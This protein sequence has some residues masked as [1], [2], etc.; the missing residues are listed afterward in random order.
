[1]NLTDKNNMICKNCKYFSCNISKNSKIDDP[2]GYCLKHD[3]QPHCN[4]KHKCFVY[5]DHLICTKAT[6]SLDG[7]YLCRRCGRPLTSTDSISRGFGE[8]CYNIYLKE[9]HKLS[10]RL[11]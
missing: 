2:I 4:D 6:L 3:I 9:L 10:S 1:M 7:R 11:F 5:A 8:T